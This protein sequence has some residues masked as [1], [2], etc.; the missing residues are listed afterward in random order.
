MKRFRRRQFESE[1]DAELRFHI[2]ARV[3]DLMRDGVPRG[4]ADRRA[5][6]EF[7]GVEGTKEE[8]R[9]SW[10]LNHLD[11][12]RADLRLTCR[13]LGRNRAFAAVAILSLALGIGAN[14]A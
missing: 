8:C 2:E 3:A 1:M 14:T 7:G 5:R 10:G 4:E 9:R 12:L 6:A 13:M 11:D